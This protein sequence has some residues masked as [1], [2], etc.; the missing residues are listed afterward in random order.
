MKKTVTLAAIAKEFGVSTVTVSKALSGQKGVSEKLRQRIIRLADEWDYRQPSAMKAAAGHKSL[1]IAVL[2]HEKY[3]DR[4]DAFCLRLYQHV[5]AQAIKTECVAMMD[6]VTQALEDSGELPR[7]L[8]EKKV[9]GVIVIGKIPDEYLSRLTK[10]LEVPFVCMD[11]Q[12]RDQK[13]EAVV[14]DGFYGAY[15]LTNYLLG[16][17]HRKIAYVG[18]IRESGSIMDRYLGYVKALL[19]RGETVWSH[20]LLEDRDPKTHAILRPEQL[21]LPARMPTAFVCSCDLTANMLVHRLRSEGLRVPENISVVGY[22]N[23]TYS[24]VCDVEI[25]TFEVDVRG[26]ACTA[27]DILRKR[28]E[29]EPRRAST[30]IIS[31]Q[32]VEKDSVRQID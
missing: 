29:G 10:R 15:S 11:Y 22:D 6:T 8:E 13:V 26:M 16:L 21:V 1:D 28:I 23:S 18:S 30:H 19:E 27:V 7:L 32:I 24:G 14:S 4:S 20:W 17:G 2:I 31:G 5:A 9:D 3:L 25:T 12:P